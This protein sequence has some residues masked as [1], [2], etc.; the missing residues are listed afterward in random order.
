MFHFLKFYIV[1]W[2]SYQHKKDQ[3]SGG[4]GLP[5]WSSL[6]AW[7]RTPSQHS[8]GWPP[9]QHGALSS[10]SARAFSPAREHRRMHKHENVCARTFQKSLEE[11]SLNRWSIKNQYPELFFW[12]THFHCLNMLQITLLKAGKTFEGFYNEYTCCSVKLNNK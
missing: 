6:A 12:N 2:F 8:S 10:R 1:V 11:I 7:G 4:K 5:Q 3:L 9:E